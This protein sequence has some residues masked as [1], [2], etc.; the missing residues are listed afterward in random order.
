MKVE[1]EWGMKCF[2]NQCTEPVC[3][4]KTC[5][6]VQIHIHKWRSL[7]NDTWMLAWT[8]PSRGWSCKWIQVWAHP[9]LSKRIITK[10]RY[11]HN[12]PIIRRITY[13]NSYNLDGLTIAWL[14]WLTTKLLKLATRDKLHVG[15]LING[16][17]HFS[18]ILLIERCRIDLKI[19]WFR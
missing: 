4:R 17:W 13:Y 18:W 10:P 14:S 11:G 9:S 12:H 19:I 15:H 16:R 5:K 7:S 2:I 1:R 8:H 6:Q 3:H